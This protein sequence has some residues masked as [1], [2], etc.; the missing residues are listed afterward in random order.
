M[1]NKN[2]L[3]F[4]KVS[5]VVF[6]SI[7]NNWNIYIVRYIYKYFFLFSILFEHFSL[8]FDCLL[9]F[10]FGCTHMRHWFDFDFLSTFCLP[11]EIVQQML[12]V[13]CGT[14]PSVKQIFFGANFH[15]TLWPAVTY[16]SS[17]Y[18]A[19][20]KR[21]ATYLLIG[22]NIYLYKHIYIYIYGNL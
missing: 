19:E 2:Y 12:T 14:F 3:N 20:T 22:V 16:L 15:S 13:I 1:N 7:S 11:F 18:R 10:S 17:I 5:S 21:S 8:W 4:K 6:F 9:T